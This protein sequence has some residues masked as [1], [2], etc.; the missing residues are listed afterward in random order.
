MLQFFINFYNRAEYSLGIL[1]ST[2]LSVGIVLFYVGGIALKY[3][4]H[5]R[6]AASKILNPVKSNDSN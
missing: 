2:S 6:L 1:P 4:I 3:K 5:N